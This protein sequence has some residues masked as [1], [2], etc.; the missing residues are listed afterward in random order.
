[1]DVRGKS[2]SAK[3]GRKKK[4]SIK[5]DV[6]GENMKEGGNGGMELQ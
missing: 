5:M 4:E 2:A 3:R 1:M 6:K